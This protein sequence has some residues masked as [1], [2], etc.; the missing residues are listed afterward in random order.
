MCQM[1][2]T[3]VDKGTDLYDRMQQHLKDIQGQTESS[4]ESHKA[5]QLRVGDIEKKLSDMQV[6]I[7]NLC[8]E[9]S[10]LKEV[11]DAVKDENKGN[12]PSKE[13]KLY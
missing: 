4:N 7:D 2:Q 3:K 6:Q 11:V 12:N 1:F 8:E 5:L 10:K 13:G 9:Q